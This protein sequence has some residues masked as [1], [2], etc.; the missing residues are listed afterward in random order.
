[1]RTTHIREARFYQSTNSKQHLSQERFLVDT[2]KQCLAKYLGTLW[3]VKL[4]DKSTTTF[5]DP[6][7]Q[8]LFR[9]IYRNIIEKALSMCILNS[10]FGFPKW[11]Y[12]CTF[13]LECSTYTTFLSALFK[14]GGYEVEPT[15]FLHV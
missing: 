1:M 15:V 10:E 8:E 5:S 3:P 11:L 7:V 2:P 9:N 6:L 14:N 12:Q 4:S 13:L